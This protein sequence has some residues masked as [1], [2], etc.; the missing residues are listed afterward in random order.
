M[1]ASEGARDEGGDPPS[2]L[3]KRGR[4]SRKSLAFRPGRKSLSNWSSVLG[5]GRSRSNNDDNGIPSSVQLSQMH[6]GRKSNVSRFSGRTSTMSMETPLLGLDHANL[7][8]SV[9]VN[10]N[11][12]A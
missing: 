8:R 2:Q 6:T 9:H 4:K 10:N 3:Q 1:S 5:E 7:S 12:D 11:R